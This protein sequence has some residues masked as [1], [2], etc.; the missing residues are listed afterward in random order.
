MQAAAIYKGRFISISTI[1]L[2]RYSRLTCY[3]TEQVQGLTDEGY[4]SLYPS[5]CL[6]L[7]RLSEDGPWAVLDENLCYTGFLTHDQV[8]GMVAEAPGDYD[9][10]S[11][12]IAEGL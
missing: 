6:P 8:M 12:E 11:A 2:N 7:V 4:L 9:T 5:E 3:D 10:A 1:S